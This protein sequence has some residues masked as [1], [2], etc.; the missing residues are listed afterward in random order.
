EED[1]DS[2]PLAPLIDIVFQLLI[3][4]VVTYSLL[5]QERELT[6][7]LPRVSDLPAVKA[8]PEEVIINI[9]ENGALIVQ[10]K[11]WK[12]AELGEMLKTM[13]RVYSRPPSVIIRA[14][15][16][17]KYAYPVDVIAVCGAAGIHEIAFVT[18]KSP[19]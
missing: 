7:D 12:L 3:F 19:E 11:V 4:F 8:E 16:D 10:E 14:D 17:V 6:V 18:W 9:T 1:T 15:R 2:I 13:T 5:Q